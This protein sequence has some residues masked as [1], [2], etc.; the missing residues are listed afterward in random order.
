[1]VDRQKIAEI[2]VPVF[3]CR[4]LWRLFLPGRWQFRYQVVNRYRPDYDELRLLFPAAPDHHRDHKEAGGTT[5]PPNPAPLHATN[6][7]HWFPHALLRSYHTGVFVAALLLQSAQPLSFTYTELDNIG[8]E[9]G[10]VRRDPSDV[11]EVEGVFYVWYTKVVQGAE[12]YPSGS[13][14]TVWF[15]TSLDGLQWQEQG[16]AVA[17]G[18]DGAWDE[19]SVFTP[20]ILALGDRYYLYY[21]AVPKPFRNS[22]ARIT[23]TAIGVA[24]SRSPRGPWVKHLE[25]PVVEASWDYNDFD[26]L[27]VDDACL[28]V[29]S[30]VVHLYYKGRAWNGSPGQ[31]MMGVALASSPLGPFRKHMGNPVVRGGHEVMVWPREGGV[32]SIHSNAGEEGRTLQLSWDGLSFEKVADQTQ[33]P[34]APGAFRQADG[35]SWGISMRHGPHPYLV[36]YDVSRHQCE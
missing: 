35:L 11:I 9:E 30:G 14:G 17:R 1:M 31:T 22:G 34:L 3:F 8:F 28:L 25:N 6:P 10:V 20:N 26:S 21:T 4:Y 36:R 5:A 33:Y 15:A 2:D 16:E 27:R 18:G 7:L 24:V 13:D 23:R 32:M 29:R 19:Q 12:L